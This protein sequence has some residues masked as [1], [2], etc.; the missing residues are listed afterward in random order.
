M[1][2]FLIILAIPGISFAG[3]FALSGVGG[4]A[5]SLAG[6]YVSIADDW[7]AVYWNPAGLA[8]AKKGFGIH[9]SLAGIFGDATTKTGIVGMDG[10]YSL[11]NY[12]IN[13]TQSFLIPA[14]GFVLPYKNQYFGFA[15]YVPFGLG[16]KWDLYS[17]PIGYRDDGLDNYPK[18][19]HESS[20]EVINAVLGYG[21][22]ISYFSF[23]LAIGI[24]RTSILLRKV[25]F[26][27]LDANGDKIPDLGYP[28]SYM[29]VDVKL[30]GSG[31]GFV[32]NGG[33]KYEIGPLRAGLAVRY[34]SSPKINGE[35][36]ANVYFPKNSYYYNSSGGN[37]IFL[38]GI[39]SS[40][41]KGDAVLKLP[42]ILDFGLAYKLEKITLSGFVQY[43]G[44]NSFDVIKL[45]IDSS[46]Q[47][48]D[49]ILGKF[50]PS[51]EEFIENW[52]S[53]FKFGLGLEYRIIQNTPLRIGFA[54][55]Q[56]PVPDSTFTP[57]IP[58]PGNKIQLTGGFS[59]EYNNFSY[60]INF[61]Y[62]IMPRKE[63]SKSPY[64]LPGEYKFSIFVL[65]FGLNYKF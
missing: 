53:T 36:S 20:I 56:S 40:S 64:N 7:T 32:L 34:N 15:L 19:D 59:R 27:L 47:T 8:N 38:G 26:A 4:K 1:R 50:L 43:Q 46:N 52:K 44:W 41:A 51:E 48:G 45:N 9:G 58:D 35:I 31:W 28:Y 3:G 30:T 23:G 60:D 5:L 10:P 25:D 14:F 29:P 39:G 17:L 24:S 57:L 13:S 65:G 55:D 11:K 63:V 54:F 62:F 16:T 2:K 49:K 61:E 33:V 37:P 22:K 18:I 21:K 42:L 12:P 6:S